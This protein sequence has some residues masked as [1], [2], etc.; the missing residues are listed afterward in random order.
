MNFNSRKRTISTKQPPCVQTDFILALIIVILVLIPSSLA[1]QKLVQQ[2]LDPEGIPWGPLKYTFYIFPAAFILLFIMTIRFLVQFRRVS[3]S[4][5]TLKLVLIGSSIVWPFLWNAY[6]AGI[7]HYV[8]FMYGFLQRMHQDADVFA[9]QA[10]LKTEGTKHERFLDKSDYPEAVRILE[11]KT[12]W[13]ERNEKDANL[14]LKIEWGG[15]LLGHWGLAV[16]SDTMC[17]PPCDLRM[18][19]E[20]RLPLAKGAYIWYNW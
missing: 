2:G 6:N 20:Y 11:P 12:A 5:L 3:S 10:W 7:P 1:S 18:D 13:L 4:Q 15:A 19:G 17:C 9:I 14:Y 16:G 8:P